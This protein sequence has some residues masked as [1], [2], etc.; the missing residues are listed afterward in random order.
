MGI[1]I[2]AESRKIIH[3]GRMGENLATAVIF[4]VS[5]QIAAIGANGTFSLLVL[6][7]GELSEVS[8]VQIDDSQVEWDITSNYTLKK[9]KGKCQ[10]I[11]K[12]NN[13]IISKSEIYDLIVTFGYGETVP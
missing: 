13:T 8:L 11:Y 2:F 10:V 4:N 9:G 6:Q 3:I 1:K 5:E 7:N 12:V